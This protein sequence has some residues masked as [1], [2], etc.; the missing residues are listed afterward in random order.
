MRKDTLNKF[1]AA[2][3]CLL[4]LFQFNVSGEE[5]RSFSKNNS[6]HDVEISCAVNNLVNIYYDNSQHHKSN[7]TSNETGNNSFSYYRIVEDS[8]PRNFFV[9]YFY[10]DEDILPIQ[11]HL[12]SSDQK[13][14]PAN[15]NK[16][17]V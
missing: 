8:F 4:I 9:S 11:R 5:D 17:S 6:S 7:K 2:L 16:I 1:L 10:F 14:P 15:I 13:S 12:L 3:Q